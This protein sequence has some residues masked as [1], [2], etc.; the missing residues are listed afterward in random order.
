MAGNSHTLTCEY[1]TVA[2]S[3][4]KSVT[5]TVNGTDI[6]TSEDSHISTSGVGDILT[7]SPLTTAD[8]GNYTC[9]LTL[10]AA[11]YYVTVPGPVQ[12][13]KAVILV[14]SNLFNFFILDNNNTQYFFFS[15]FSSL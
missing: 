5:W 2:V 7:F 13:P 14:K 10:T 11:P 1:S 4:T 15:P 8:A 9:I 6:D 12:S 3:V